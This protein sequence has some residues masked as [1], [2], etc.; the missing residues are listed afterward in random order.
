VFL[1]VEKELGVPELGR[2]WG[3]MMQE[4]TCAAQV[5]VRPDVLVVVCLPTLA[6]LGMGERGSSQ[7]HAKKN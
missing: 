5:R 6:R 3:S 1:F 7:T 4:G 2:I